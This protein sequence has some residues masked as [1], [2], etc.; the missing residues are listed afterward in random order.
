MPAYAAFLQDDIRIS[1]NLVLNLGVRY[2]PFI[3]YVDN[4]NRVSVYRPGQTSRVFTNAPTGLLFV[5]DPGVSRGGTKADINNMAPRFGF[6]WSPFGNSRTAIRG[7]Y[8]IFFDSA[9]MSAIANV[10][11]NVAPFGTRITQIPPPGPFDDPY[12][13]KNPFPMPFP[14]PG[15][16][17]FPNSISAATYPDQL[18]TAY[19]QDWNLTVEREVFQSLVLRASYAGSKGTGL[20]QGWEENQAVYIPGA[21]TVANTASRQPYAPAFSNIE[22][23]DG[24]SGSSYNSLQ[25]SADKR[26]GRGFTILANYTWAKSIDYGSGAGTLWPDFT[27][28]H[29]HNI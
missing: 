2:E 14:P 1:H 16:V 5:G 3:P 20:L 15:N 23:V 25:L 28:P 19:L 29:N 18:R 9:P 27:D 21:S 13:G 22:V 12:L 26:F 7:G 17:E 24:V 10:F 11:Q 6:A 4:G 8:G